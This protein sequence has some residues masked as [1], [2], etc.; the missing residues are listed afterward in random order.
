MSFPRPVAYI[1]GQTPRHPEGLFEALR[2]TVRP[3]MSEGALADCDALRAGLYYLDEGLFWEAHEVLEPV[4]MAC[5]PNSAAR[6]VAQALIQIANARL[7]LRMGRRQAA[8]RIAALAGRHVT[9]VRHAGGEA[10]LG[11]SLESLERRLEALRQDL[12]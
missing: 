2:A 9:E 4:W 8:A 11:Q 3:G 10:P 1:P 6:Q 5:P 7:K 12:R